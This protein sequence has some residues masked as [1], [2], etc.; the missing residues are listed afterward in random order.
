MP[1]AQRWATHRGYLSPVII[2]PWALSSRRF[3]AHLP[4][5]IHSLHLHLLITLDALPGLD[6][7]CALA[8][9]MCCCLRP[10][11]PTLYT[12]VCSAP[13]TTSTA[14]LCH[15]FCTTSPALGAL[16]LLISEAARTAQHRH[17]G[18]TSTQF[19]AL[20][21]GGSPDRVFFSLGLSAGHSHCE[22]ASVKTLR[23]H[24]HQSVLFAAWLR[25]DGSD[26]WAV[27]PAWRATLR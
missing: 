3:S 27:T 20:A 15:D 18:D 5:A 25:A 19:L 16:I 22:S 12:V 2:A 14:E 17:H 13:E 1:L 24:S 7:E 26:L 6:T 11:S 9:Q 10:A 23:C 21:L 8:A 4:T